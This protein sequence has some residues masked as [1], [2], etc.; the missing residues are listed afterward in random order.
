[1]I[2]SETYSTPGP[3]R[4]DLDVPWG[5]V[6][7]DAGNTDETHVELEA[8]SRSERVR[9]LVASAR[10]EH[11]RRGDGHEVV[12]SVRG[13][14]GFWISFGDDGGPDLSLRITCPHGA[15][16]DV[17]TRSAD[18]EARGEFGSAEVKTASGDIE[19]QETRGEL[20]VKTASGDIHVERV[21]SSLD[22]NS[23]SGD[24]HVGSV[25]ADV[26]A[27][28]V[29]GD[30]SV[31]EVGGSI[32]AN[33]VS[34][35]QRFEAIERGRVDLKAISGSVNVGIRRGSRL[36]VDANTVSGSTSSELELS[37]SPSEQPSE[38]APL[39]ELFVKTVSGDIRIDRAPAR[40][41][42]AEVSESA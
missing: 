18:L 35:D 10:I 16:L 28:L 40:A 2:R 29:S 1:M 17:R 33:T 12:V 15:D 20:K 21:G 24:L 34:G 37:D 36:Y 13:R 3:V 4:L 39:V 19:V 6:Q 38:D 42:P 26:R 11:V 27:Q 25:A 41:V 5:E 8:L 22:V 23:V 30:V 32:S 9:E 31:G 14:H 7:I